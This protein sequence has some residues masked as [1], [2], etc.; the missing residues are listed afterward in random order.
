VLF[1]LSAG[2]VVATDEPG[3]TLG[4][5]LARLAA[6]APAW[7]V[8]A[9]RLTLHSSAVR[10]ELR[11]LAAL[12]VSP[13]RGSRG[14]VLA[15]WCLALAAL[16]CLTL[17]WTDVTSLFPAVTA[18]TNWEP[19]ADGLRDAA[20]GVLV[21][22]DGGIVIS[23]QV[24]PPVLRLGPGRDAA[25]ACLSPVALMA[26]VWGAAPLSLSGRLAGGFATAIAA[27]VLLHAR[28]AGVVPSVALGAA[29]LPLVLQAGFGWWKRSAT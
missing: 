2:V 1:V 23:T 5:R 7:V 9:Q 20:S 8:V 13:W 29:T 3:S 12:G 15:G 21:H 6:L 24:V 16:G 10:G 4:M 17:P 25:L 11:A 27:V 28:A 19:V 26:P 18:P 22:P 14:V